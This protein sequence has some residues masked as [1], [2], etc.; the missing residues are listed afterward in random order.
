[1]LLLITKKLLQVGSSP[2]TEREQPRMHNTLGH[3]LNQGCV[4][5]SPKQTVS[6]FMEH[7]G[8]SFVLAHSVPNNSIDTNSVPKQVVIADTI[9]SNLL[10]CEV[11]AGMAKSN[12]RSTVQSSLL[13]ESVSVN[14]KRRLFSATPTQQQQ[15][16]YVSHEARLTW[17]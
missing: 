6:Q 9:P 16:D 4:M 3:T 15:Q 12:V 8:F 10:V 13:Y 1:M 11:N 7:Q 14:S 2:L 5:Q 17:L